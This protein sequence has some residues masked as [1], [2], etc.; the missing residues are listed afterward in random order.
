MFH[1]EI[2]GSSVKISY[3]STGGTS[4]QTDAQLKKLHDGGKFTTFN[5]PPTVTEQHQKTVVL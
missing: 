5:P 2:S 1:L 3:R 4:R